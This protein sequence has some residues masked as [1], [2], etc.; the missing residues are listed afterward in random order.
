M[1]LKTSDGGDLR[2]AEGRESAMHL[3]RLRETHASPSP[4]P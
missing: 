4:R 1:A 2:V 3:V